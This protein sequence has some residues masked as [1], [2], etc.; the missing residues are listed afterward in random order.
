MSAAPYL[1][2]GHAQPST[3]REDEAATHSDLL[4]RRLP[5]RARVGHCRAAVQHAVQ[6][7][8][9]KLLHG[10]PALPRGQL[11]LP[12]LARPQAVQP[13]RCAGLPSCSWLLAEWGHLTAPAFLLSHAEL[14]CCQWLDLSAPGMAC[15]YADL[16]S[17]ALR[18][19]QCTSASQRSQT[20]ATWHRC[21]SSAA[22]QHSPEALLRRAQGPQS[23][24]CRDLAQACSWPAQL[25]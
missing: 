20:A 23:A 16:L 12:R 6:L 4:D 10:C 1:I 3:E 14:S 22:G 5:A 7:K 11:Q 18:H 13:E 15:H 25:D 2:P 9:C 8:P 19:T 24:L 21:I 17:V